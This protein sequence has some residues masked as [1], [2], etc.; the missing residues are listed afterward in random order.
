MQIFFYAG[1]TKGMGEKG[2]TA[3]EGF[4]AAVEAT[5]LSES[6]VSVKARRWRKYSEIST[7]S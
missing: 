2:T 4:S 1:G 3:W 6:Q 5:P 7:G